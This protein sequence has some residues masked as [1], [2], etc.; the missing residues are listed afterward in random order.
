MLAWTDRV[1]SKSPKTFFAREI[2]TIRFDSK[3]AFHLP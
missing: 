3:F 2:K 1:I